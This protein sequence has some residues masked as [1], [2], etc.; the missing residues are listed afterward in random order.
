MDTIAAIATPPGV[1]ALGILRLT[2]PEA[3][4]VASGFLALK[5]WEPRRA[6]LSRAH[7]EASPIDHVVATWFP[8]P[9][10]ATGEDLVEVSTHG[11]P[12]ILGRL[13]KAALSRGAR[14]AE[15]GEFTQRA[16]LNGRLDLAQAEAVAELIRAKTDRAHRAALTRLEGG[17]SRAVERLRAPILDLLVGVEAALDHPE[18]DL[19]APGPEPTR[20]A[21]L[22][23]RR[24]VLGLAETFKVGRLLADGARVCLVGRPNAGKSSL[25]NAL[26]GT[27]R[28]IV[29][30]TPGTT[31]DTLEEAADFEGIPGF[32]IDTA[33]LREGAQD[34][35]EALGLERSE[36]ALRT[37][38]L[39][40]LVIDRSRPQGPEDERVHR[41]ILETSARLGRPLVAVLNKSDLPAALHMDGVPVSAKSGS[42]LRELSRLIAGRLSSEAAAGDELVVCSLRHAKALDLAAKALSEAEQAVA[43]YPG[44]WEDRAASWLREALGRLD[45]ITGPGAPGERAPDELLREIFSRFCIGK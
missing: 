1:G 23:A 10:S 5:G 6:T 34:E 7:D 45:E 40:L 22:Q 35:A 18:E 42:G 21:L 11:S 27:D 29:C 25:L 8:G 2:G 39:G 24:K 16:F 32:L 41:R 20:E 19:P 33:G 37:A 36:R 14:L 13:L 44:R 43:K 17:L 26:L 28:A 38:D 30:P 15:P 4:A 9:N 12:Y 3:R 31:R